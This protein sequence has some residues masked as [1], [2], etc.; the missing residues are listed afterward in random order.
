MNGAPA[1]VVAPATWLSDKV[2]SI[3]V[4]ELPKPPL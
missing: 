3:T 1:V 2:L 4:T